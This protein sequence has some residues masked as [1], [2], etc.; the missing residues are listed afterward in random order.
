MLGS[1]GDPP[2]PVARF[3]GPDQGWFVENPKYDS[4]PTVLFIRN[5]DRNA[6]DKNW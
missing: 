6:P 5:A 1:R 4:P 3:I 2:G